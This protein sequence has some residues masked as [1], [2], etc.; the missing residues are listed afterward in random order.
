MNRPATLGTAL[1]AAVAC[2]GRGA[3]AQCQAQKLVAAD[4]GGGE[5][6]GRVISASGDWLIVGAPF[7]AD[8][9]VSAGSAYVHQ[10]QGTGWI[11]TQKLFSSDGG[12][13]DQFGYAV[14]ISGDIAVVTAIA[15]FPMG[16]FAAGSAYVFERSGATWV[17]TTKLF[18]NDAS[19]EDHFGQAVAISGNRIVFGVPH[20]DPAGSGSGSAYVFEKTGGVWAQTAKL[21]PNGLAPAD[22][23]GFS[24]AIEGDTIVVGSLGDE[25]PSGEGNTGSAYV[26]EFSMGSW[27]EKQKLIPSDPAW[28][29][30]FGASVSVS[31]ATLLVGAGTDSTSGSNSGSV[32]AFEKQGSVW[33]QVQELLAIDAN[34]GNV[35]GYFHTHVGNV[36]IIGSIGDSDTSFTCGSA[37]EFRRVGSTW[38]QTGKMLAADGFQG[39]VLGRSV[40]ITGLTAIAGAPFTDDACTTNPGCD[41]GAVYAFELSTSAVQYGSCRLVAPCNN[42]DLHGGCQ[43]GTGQGGI[44]AACGSG[45]ISADDLRL[46]L[47]RCPPNKLSLLFMGPA[48]SQVIF[49]NGVR[50][51]GPQNPTG[52]YRFG[53][54]AADAQG[55]VMR[56]PGLVAYSQGFPPLGRIQ[57]GQ[58]WNFEYWYRDPNGPCGSNTNFTNGVKV[59]FGP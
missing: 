2:V 41:S 56:G 58:T 25:G 46:E 20:D 47:T 42:F 18:A 23:F 36:A 39:G 17:E 54:A 55:R 10:K 57:A 22:T 11:Q 51:A 29:Q 31:G 6:F 24:V 40:A 7:D 30:S 13:S 28:D 5:E 35:F 32:Y 48:Q 27:I 37:Y 52:I 38:T 16:I 15:D 43:N 12:S 45:S 21:T 34:P 33:T 53:G 59:T 3:S 8:F 9:G 14:G 49:S 19:P 26:F 44:I 50:V 4:A 1:F